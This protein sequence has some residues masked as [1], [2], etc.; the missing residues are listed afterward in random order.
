MSKKVKSFKKQKHFPYY[1]G[2]G[3]FSHLIE[4][5]FSVA[6][7]A[8]LQLAGR[9][10]QSIRGTV[11][12]V[13]H[14]DADAWFRKRHPASQA[15]TKDSGHD[16]L[17]ATVFKIFVQTDDE[18]NIRVSFTNPLYW[19]AAYSSSFDEKDGQV[20]TTV[21]KDLYTVVQANSPSC[22]VE[23]HPFGHHGHGI[24]T[25]KLQ[26]YQYMFGMPRRRDQVRLHKY[27]DHDEAVF[28]VCTHLK[29]LG[30]F[31][32]SKSEANVT[33]VGVA[34]DADC[35]NHPGDQYHSGSEA[36]FMPII[37]HGPLSHG[38]ALPYEIIIKDNIAY[39]L[40]GRFRIALSFPSLTMV[41]FSKIMSTPGGVEHAMADLFA[42]S[43]PSAEEVKEV[44]EKERVEKVA[45]EMHSAEVVAAAEPI[46]VV[47]A[48]VDSKESIAVADP[49]APAPAPAP[50]TATATAPA[51]ATA[52][53][54]A[55]TTAP[56]TATAATVEEP[57]IVDEAERK[58]VGETDT[59]TDETSTSERVL[60]EEPEVKEPVADLAAIVIEEPTSAAPTVLP[61]PIHSHEPVYSS[62]DEFDMEE[63]T[64]STWWTVTVS[65]ITSAIVATAV[66]TWFN[67]G[68]TKFWS[69]NT[70]AKNGK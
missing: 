53:A 41:T 39:M 9:P 10:H 45:A 44:E 2:E 13:T 59:T 18:K 54:T 29:H 69:T 43:V 27:K 61:T 4:Q 12:P 17:L 37:D 57:S 58:S 25:S 63:V 22:Q 56:A 47:S 65:A 15:L 35:M 20:F 6:S 21:L 40:H 19:G 7:V 51:T 32:Y 46:A 49:P 23:F 5:P 60:I 52:T 28:T 14:A 34:L 50:A 55:T 68:D 8:A 48:A 42:A 31:V 62:D 66:C 3:S 33:T 16:E 1:V 26:S 36:H 70:N 38:A 67:S 64:H 30:C 11:F 24:S